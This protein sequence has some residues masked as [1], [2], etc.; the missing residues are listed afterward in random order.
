LLV[1]GVPLA[2]T[3]G[4]NLVVGNRAA[5]DADITFD[6][7]SAA[8]TL[9]LRVIHHAGYGIQADLPLKLGAAP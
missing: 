8:K 1:D 9:A 3:Y 7:P 2:P 4:L 6:V 5:L